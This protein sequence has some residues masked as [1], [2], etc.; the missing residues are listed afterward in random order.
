MLGQEALEGVDGRLH[1]IAVAGGEDPV[2]PGVEIAHA[3]AFN[4][5]ARRAGER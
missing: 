1:P 2:Y 5:V 4:R 3:G